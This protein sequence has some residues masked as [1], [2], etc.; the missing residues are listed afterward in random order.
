M[1]RRIVQP[2]PVHPQRIDS[3]RVRGIPVAFEMEPDETLLAALTGPLVKAGMQSAS[4]RFGGGALSPFRY[5]KPG[6]PDGPQHVAYFS[7]PRCPDGETRVDQAAVTFGWNGAEPAV[8]IHG[9]WTEQGGDRRGGHMLPQECVV[10][11]RMKVEG[12]GFPDSR[13]DTM[14]DPETNFTLFQLA[15]THPAD[16]G[17]HIVA[18]IR[19]NEDITLAAEAAARRHGVT[20][21]AIFGTLGSLIGAHFADG[22]I[23]QADA[24]EVLVRQ[25]RLRDGV[26]ELD[27]IVVDDHGRAEEGLLLRGENPVLITFDLVLAPI[28]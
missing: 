19:P 24:T 17:N 22:R 1:M 15:K 21:A 16:S 6:P 18:R 23:V 26:A 5:V 2:G 28:E 10:R 25:G 13:I 3:R 14:P 7:A 9:V 12:I 11:T 20:D 27:M 4:L 8:H